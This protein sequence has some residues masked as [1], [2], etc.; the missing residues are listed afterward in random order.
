M[1]SIKKLFSFFLD[2]SLLSFLIIGGV[3]TILSMSG[4]FVL[5]NY[6]NWSLFASTAIMFAVLS[7]PSFY[8]NRKYSFKSNA[9]LGKSIARFATLVTACFL[10]S[11]SLNNLV[12]PLLRDNLFPNI[13]EMLYSFIAI[14]G[15]QVVFT[16]LNYV[17]QRIWAFKE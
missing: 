15:I 11:F 3:N 7:I 6:F 8:F 1:K 4:S 17:G 12:L 9:P 13:N 5:K 2:K 14:V 16:M 10:L